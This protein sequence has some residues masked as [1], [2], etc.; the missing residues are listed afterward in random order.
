MSPYLII[1]IS[2]IAG[3]IPV[4]LYIGKIFFHKDVREFGSGNIGAS[5]V[6]R[7]FGRGAGSAAFVLDILKGML[8]VLAARHYFPLHP[9]IQV[10]TGIAA[11]IGH[12]NSV[13][14]KFTGGKGVATSCGVA[15]A[16]SW[17]AAAA[18]ASV[19]LIITFVTGFISLGSILSAPVTGFFIWKFNHYS[20]PYGIFGLMVGLTVIYKHRSNIKRLLAGNELSI[21]DKTLRNVAASE[22][23]KIP[24]DTDLRIILASGSPRRKEL[25]ATLA[26]K[27]DVI[28]STVD[29][30]ALIEQLGDVPPKKLVQEL[31]AA[32]AIDV[33]RSNPDAIVIGADTV[34]VID[35]EI[36]GKPVDTTD[37]YNML[38]RLSGRTHE[39]FT[40]IAVIK[41]DSSQSDA[42]RTFV[43]FKP[44]S[45]QEISAYIATGDPMDKAGSYGIQN[46]DISPVESIDGD[47]YNVMGLPVEDLRTMLK[48]FF[49][50]LPSSPEQP[51]FGNS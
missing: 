5:N 48:N 26:V 42:I 28:P 2:Y 10:A 15:L 20:L 31:A 18:G 17:K 8:P 46:S 19:W 43:K 11:I 49:P 38:S 12:N 50:F 34:V 41:K 14:L 3:S 45:A 25:L 29:E 51:N 22:D 23:E 27:Y 30:T 35:G 16:L 37:A 36:L 39:V 1:L 9:W 4:G 40:G 32:K 24:T 44:W 47:Y 13:F 21:R 6:G 33:F 7:T